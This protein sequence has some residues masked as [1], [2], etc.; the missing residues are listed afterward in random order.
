MGLDYPPGERIVERAQVTVVDGPAL[1]DGDA[2]SFR[3]NF[4]APHSLMAEM[5]AR[6]AGL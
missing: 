1:A 6:I 2:G 4:A 3:F 5:I